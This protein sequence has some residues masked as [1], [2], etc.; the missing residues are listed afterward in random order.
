MVNGAIVIVLATAF[1]PYWGAPISR[2]IGGRGDVSGDVFVSMASGEVRRAGDVEILLVA[3][4][5]AM[6]E[7]WSSLHADFQ[8]DFYPTFLKYLDAQGKPDRMGEAL[9]LAVA[10]DDIVGRYNK[11]TREILEKHLH[12][13]ARTDVNGRFKFERASAGLYVL[14][15]EHRV[16]DKTLRWFEPIEVT[17]H[18]VT[19]NLS[20][21]NSM[22]AQW[23][24]A[25]LAAKSP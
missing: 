16:F 24:A 5:P 10:V 15:A 17:S 19:I 14:V 9:Q 25:D 21:S 4:T 2:L 1:W 6:V 8:R 18:G 11:R 3:K 7:S 20:N 12:Q 13:R 23:A 22:T